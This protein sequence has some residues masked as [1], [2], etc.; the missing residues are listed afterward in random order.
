MFK[1]I[2]NYIKSFCS[3]YAM[4]AVIYAETIFGSKNGSLKK[5]AAIEFIVSRLPLF[6]LPFKG[7]IKTLLS[8]I[9]DVLVEKAVKRLHQ[10]QNKIPEGIEITV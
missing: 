7:L 5:D 4:S 9:F 10:I 2:K 1:K 6:M 8:E 3:K